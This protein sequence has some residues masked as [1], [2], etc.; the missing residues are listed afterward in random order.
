MDERGQHHRPGQRPHRRV[1][2]GPARGD[3]APCGARR[4][5]RRLRAQRARR[6]VRHR[7]DP[8]PGRASTATSGCITGQKMWCTYADQADYLVVVAR[9]TPY[10]PAHRHAGIRRFYVP[11]ERGSFP[12]GMTGNADPQDRLLRLADVGAVARRPAGPGRAPARQ[13]EDAASGRGRR[14]P[15]GLARAVGRPVCTPPPARSDSAR[16]ALEDSVAYCQQRRQFDQP[17]GD[18]QAI[19]FKIAHMAAEIEACRAFM[20][21]VAA[22]ADAGVAVD[23]QASMLK[24][25]ASEMAERVTSEGIQI[26]GGAGLH[27]R[28]RGRAAL[29]RRS[30]DEDLRRHVGDPAAHHLRPLP[31]A[32]QRA[33][34]DGLLSPVRR[35]LL[36]ERPLQ[37]LAVGVAGQRVDEQRAPWA[38]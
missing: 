36:D 3:P 1:Q 19:R 2:R 15:G 35:E 11:K 4:V 6:R 26:H 18:F 10:D 29:A 30:P 27:D 25:L 12:P 16:G 20:Y 17:I 34:C 37:D 9:T 31:A 8:H 22:D 23:H 13:R 38:S 28:L 5:P 24:Y 32:T 21:Q 33:R 7:V 14:F